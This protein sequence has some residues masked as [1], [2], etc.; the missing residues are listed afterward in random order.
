M[1]V[2]ILIREIRESKNISIVELAKMTKLSKGHISK[3]ERGETRPT[4]DTL[5]IIALALKVEVS[6]LYKICY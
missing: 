3:I 2:E 5:V 6:E 1:R 4:I